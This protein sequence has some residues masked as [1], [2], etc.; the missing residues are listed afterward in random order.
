[1]A[2]RDYAQDRGKWKA[3]LIL[4]EASNIQCL[5][6]CRIYQDLPFGILQVRR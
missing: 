6:I 3:F 1:M 5:L 4:D 2:R